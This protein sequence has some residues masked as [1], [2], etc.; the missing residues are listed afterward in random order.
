MFYA[1]FGLSSLIFIVHGIIVI[2]WEAQKARM[3]L[4]WMSWMA[5]ANLTG[6]AVYAA[7]V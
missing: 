1:G 7:R 3:S 5:A 6:A 2:G 4:I